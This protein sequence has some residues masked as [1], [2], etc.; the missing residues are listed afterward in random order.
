M[1]KVIKLLLYSPRKEHFDVYMGYKV[2]KVCEHDYQEHQ[3]KNNSVRDSKN[4]DAL[5]CHQI[6]NTVLKTCRKSCLHLV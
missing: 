5:E 6:D 4:Q 3:E 1:F 2:S